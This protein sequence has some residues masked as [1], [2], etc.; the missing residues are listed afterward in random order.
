MGL[1]PKT[2]G[3]ARAPIITEERT[4]ELSEMSNA[5]ALQEVL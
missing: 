1:R 3:G 4:R 5:E 2:R